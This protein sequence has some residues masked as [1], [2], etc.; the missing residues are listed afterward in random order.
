ML[1]AIIETNLFHL[2]KCFVNKTRSEWEKR[3]LDLNHWNEYAQ[4]GRRPSAH[5]REVDVGSAFLSTFTPQLFI[6]RK[7]A[8]S[9]FPV[10]N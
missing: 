10:L 5:I 9:Y 2:K 3:R 7:G 6:N 8:G 4:D 1:C